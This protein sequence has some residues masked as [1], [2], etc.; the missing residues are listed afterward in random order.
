MLSGF[1]AVI[2]KFHADGAVYISEEDRG[3]FTIM[4]NGGMEY[5]FGLYVFLR[6]LL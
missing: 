3:Y 4:G 5:G 2:G 6:D 1:K